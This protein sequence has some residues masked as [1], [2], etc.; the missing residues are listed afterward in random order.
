MLLGVLTADERRR[1]IEAESLGLGTV[2]HQSL[3]FKGC[4]LSQYTSAHD[5]CGREVSQTVI[6]S[7]SAS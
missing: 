7:Y 3:A 2:V 5:S 6:V 4:T 1:P